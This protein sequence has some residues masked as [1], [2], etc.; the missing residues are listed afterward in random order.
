VLA[1][2]ETP[3]PVKQERDVSVLFVA[4]GGY[5]QLTARVAPEKLNALVEHYFSRFLGDDTSE[6][7]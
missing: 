3:E 1:H 7:R 6:G 2:P 4:I 5:A